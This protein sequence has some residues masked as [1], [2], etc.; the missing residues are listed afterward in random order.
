[1]MCRAR[2]KREC[3]KV[4]PNLQDYVWWIWGNPVEEITAEGLNIIVTLH[5]LGIKEQGTIIL[6]RGWR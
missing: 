1:M 4:Y 6:K 5:I 2:I 3:E